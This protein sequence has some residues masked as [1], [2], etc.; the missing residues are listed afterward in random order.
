[1]LKWW[2]SWRLRRATCLHARWRAE[3]EA[4]ECMLATGDP[5]Y[6]CNPFNRVSL[7]RAA[8]KEAYYCEL[9]EQLMR[10]R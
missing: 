2:R 3:R 7:V 8:G 1:M 10:E 9:V 5:S 4:K 6:R